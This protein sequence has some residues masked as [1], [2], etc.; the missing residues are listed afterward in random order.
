MTLHDLLAPWISL[1]EQNPEQFDEISKRIKVSVI[2]KTPN[3]EVEYL[4][5]YTCTTIADGSMAPK[6]N[7]ICCKPEDI[8]NFTDTT[9]KIPDNPKEA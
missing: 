2:K 9:T 8:G 6:V 1:R 4:E 7:I 3:G 5:P